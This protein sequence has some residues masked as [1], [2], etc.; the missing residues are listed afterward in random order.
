M[1]E[2]PEGGYSYH[3]GIAQI[4]DLLPAGVTYVSHSASYGTFD[5]ATGKW[6]F[7]M[8]YPAPA[9]PLVLTLNTT[10]ANSGTHQNVANLSQY[11]LNLCG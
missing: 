8:G 7:S 5:S 2:A 3:I 11:D 1:P 4:S 10:A 6:E 9:F